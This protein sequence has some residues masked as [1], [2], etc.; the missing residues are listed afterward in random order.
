MDL[1]SISSWTRKVFQADL[2]IINKSTYQR[3]TESEAL[4]GGRAAIERA[5]ERQARILTM[6]STSKWCSCCGDT[7]PKHYFDPASAAPDGLK[8]WCRECSNRIERKRYHTDTEYAAKKREAARERYR[9]KQG[10]VR[11]YNSRYQT[12][13]V[14]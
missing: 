3:V 11:P 8:W 13:T 7:R 10:D 12:A 4:R 1:S 9:A 5:L 2:G 6:D 14:G